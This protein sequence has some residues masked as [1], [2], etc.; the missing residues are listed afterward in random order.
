[1]GE[2]NNS[3]NNMAKAY[4]IREK[5][6]KMSSVGNMPRVFEHS[7]K[8][9]YILTALDSINKN[10]FEESEQK[11]VESLCEGVLESLKFVKIESVAIVETAKKRFENRG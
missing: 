9:E 1:M 11:R 3:I 6:L 5:W 10:C 8:A 7:F 4:R 2:S